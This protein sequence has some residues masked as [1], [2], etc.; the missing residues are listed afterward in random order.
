MKYSPGSSPLPASR[1]ANTRIPVGVDATAR[2]NPASR[3]QLG[4]SWAL[5]LPPTFSAAMGRLADPLLDAP[6]V[7]S[8]RCRSDRDR[9]EVVA[10][11]SGNG[12]AGGAGE[13]RP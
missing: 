5:P 12:E 6:A 7:S 8:R 1:K 3:Q 10:R 9:R 11:E 2:W 4:L 13:R